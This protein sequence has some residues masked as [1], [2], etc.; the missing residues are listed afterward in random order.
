MILPP[1]DARF[2]TEDTDDT[3]DTGG[4]RAVR[5]APVARLPAPEE[6]DDRQPP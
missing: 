2:R 5:V 4:P 1:H 3:D 6:R